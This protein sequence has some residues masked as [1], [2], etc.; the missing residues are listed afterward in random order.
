MSPYAAG[1]L[2]SPQKEIEADKIKLAESMLRKISAEF[3]AANDPA[4]EALES[5]ILLYGKMAAGFARSG[6][7]GNLLLAD[8]VL[9]LAIYR[10]S[11]WLIYHTDDVVE[12][13]KLLKLVAMPKVNVRSLLLDLAN[14]DPVTSSRH[15]AISALQERATILDASRVLGINYGDVV[16]SDRS[17]SVLLQKPSAIA[18]V[19]RMAETDALFEVNIK[20]MLKFFEK[21]GDYSEIDSREARPF[22]RRMLGESSKFNSPAIGVREFGV[23]H[24]ECLVRIHKDLNAKNAY[25]NEATK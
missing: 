9:R 2:P 16:F 22:Y 12:V 21:G 18:V 24:V 25:L 11:G 17:T 14:Q 20:G 10:I 13:N 19:Y 4:K 6:G 3:V 7:Y 15:D 23:N 1:L 5:E 8:A